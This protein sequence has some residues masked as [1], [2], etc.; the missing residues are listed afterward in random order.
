MSIPHCSPQVTYVI[1]P[2]T[3]APH[4]PPSILSCVHLRLLGVTGSFW[5][6]LCHAAAGCLVGEGCRC[7]A[8]V[9]V[10]GDHTP[11]AAEPVV[12]EHRPTVSVARKDQQQERELGLNRQTQHSARPWPSLHYSE[13]TA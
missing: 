5:V 11:A 13:H 10:R 1:S 7:S 9:C 6:V 2:Q 12:C 4:L 3:H 8:E